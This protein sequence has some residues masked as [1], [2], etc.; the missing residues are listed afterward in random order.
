MFIKSMLFRKK[1][2]P[3][4]I[5]L[6]LFLALFLSLAAVNGLGKS[7]DL[8]TD[9]AAREEY[10]E[11]LG[12]EIDK[13]SLKIKTVK[14]PE[15]F[16]DVYENYNEIQKKAGF[17]L[18][19]YR[20]KRVKIF[21]YSVLNYPEKPDGVM[22]NLMIADGRVIGGDVCTAQINGFMLPIK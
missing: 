12:W 9:A 22:L 5:A 20:G 2:V 8:S 18:S 19:L 15:K 11:N 7:A 14:I 13:T 4:G 6:G 1:S 21:T 3:V 10:I 16:G 17:D